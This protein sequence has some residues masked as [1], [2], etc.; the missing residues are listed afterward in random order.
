V[1]YYD[2][3]SDVLESEVDSVTPTEAMT[4]SSEGGYALIFEGGDDGV[5]DGTR[6]F[7]PVVVTEPAAVVVVGL[8]H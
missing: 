1:G 5:K 8:R 4:G 3:F 7:G 6:S 2:R